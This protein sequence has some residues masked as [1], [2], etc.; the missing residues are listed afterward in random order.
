MQFGVNDGPLGGRE[1]NHVTS[2]KIKDRLDR[3]AKMNVSLSIAD[4]DKSG[5]FNVSARGAMQIAVL[6][7]QMRREG[8]EVVDLPPHGHH[9]ARRT[10]CSAN[11]SKLSTW[12]CPP[13]PSAAS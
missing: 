2:R 10:A 9:P 6:V 1:G 4:T 12:T 11:P 7:E 8:F 5:I 13:S 3:E